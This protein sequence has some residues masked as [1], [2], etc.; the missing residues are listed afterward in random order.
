MMSNKPLLRK[1]L[2]NPWILL[3]LGLLIPIVSYTLW[4]LFE[5]LKLPKG[6]LP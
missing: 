2:D 6:N 4:G 3:I 5:L 1:I